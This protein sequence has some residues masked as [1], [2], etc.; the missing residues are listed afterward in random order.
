MAITA[1]PTPPSRSDPTNFA[2]RGDAFMAALPTFAT[3]ANALEAAVNADE[4]SAAASAAAAAASEAASVGYA[5]ASGT[6]AQSKTIGAGSFTFTDVPSG[7][8]W[9]AGMP[10]T[11]YYNATNYMLG[12]VTSYSGTT[13]VVSVS[14]VAG[15][16][17]YASW[18][19]W[20]QTW[21]REIPV[22]S[23]SAAYPITLADSGKCLLH[24]ASDATARTVTIPA[25][26]S[27]PF[28]IGTTITLINFGTGN[29]SVA[30][31]TDTLRLAGAGTT[32]TRAIKTNGMAT[33]IKYDTTNWMI[34]G[35]VS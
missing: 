18:A 32:G 1:L 30:I 24:P 16:G 5:N 34:S 35:V 27:V 15:S 11:V 17:T 3:E 2:S 8:S 9:V 23:I 14:T 21:Y 12:T 10:L 29:L 6:S 7:K 33:I 20:P 22:V 19:F 26:S 25:N 31:T 13:L 4:I 28:P